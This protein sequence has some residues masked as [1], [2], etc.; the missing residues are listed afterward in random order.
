MDTTLASQV[1]KLV[2][3]RIET[4]AGA[5]PNAVIN[6]FRRG[7]FDPYGKLPEGV[8]V[9]AINAF[10]KRSNETKRRYVEKRM[11]A[12]GPTPPPIDKL[13]VAVASLV[14]FGRSMEILQEMQ[15]TSERVSIW[16]MARDFL[17][18][19]QS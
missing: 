16:D 7:T 8:T 15:R 13:F 1:E 14:G 12:Y 3:W 17:S 10:R 9:E 19:S 11:A 18:E 4:M 2:V 6:S 5:N